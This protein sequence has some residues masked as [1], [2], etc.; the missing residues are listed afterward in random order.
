MQ[1][2]F[3]VTCWYVNL[4][5]IAERL[6]DTSINS[7]AQRTGGLGNISDPQ[8]RIAL[9]IT[10]ERL[11]LGWVRRNRVPTLGQLLLREEARPG[12]FFT[13]HGDFY[14]SG[15][16]RFV[17][18]DPSRW[19]TLKL[20]VVYSKFDELGMAG[21]VIMQF[22]PEHLLSESSWSTLSGHKRLIA[23]GLIEDVQ[24]DEIYSIPYLIGSLLDSMDETD[25]IQTHWS[26]RLEVFVDF[27]DSFSKV[28][29]GPRPPSS[30]LPILKGIPEKDIKQSFA[31]IIGEPEVPKDWGGERSDLF[32][33]W[34]SLAGK[35][36]STA[37][38]FKGPSRFNPM[39]MKDLGIRGDQIERMFTEPADLFV[40]QHCHSICK[41]VR[42][43][44]RAFANQAGR[45]RLFCLIDGYDTIRVLRAYGKCGFSPRQSMVKGSRKHSG[46]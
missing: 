28:R 1:T 2:D 21:R 30:E 36:I 39:E 45:P 16:S 13:H 26:S 20:P 40:L 11:L 38:V 12:K 42:G 22:H 37:F 4:R 23:I 10:A 35:R 25:I 33:T 3:D 31:D 41:P 9:S 19:R 24:N 27:I 5:R 34:V 17:K 43:V 15:L 29:E 7:L 6:G 8:E 18:A 46:E 44:M 14:C 32:S